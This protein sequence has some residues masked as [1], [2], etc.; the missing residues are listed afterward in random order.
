M[1]IQSFVKAV[2][3]IGA[4]VHEHPEGSFISGEDGSG[5]VDYDIDY[6]DARIEKLAEKHGVELEWYNPG[7]LAIYGQ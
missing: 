1:T 2:K 5:L 3:E 6:I 7:M 4:T